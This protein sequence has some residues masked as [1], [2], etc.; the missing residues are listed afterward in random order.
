ML[1]ILSAT[2]FCSI[3]DSGRAGFQRFGLPAAGPMDPFA[4]AAANLLAGNAPQDG[5]AALEIGLGGLALRGHA[6]C[7]VA[8]A[9]PGLALRCD[10]L[11]LPAWTAVYLPAGALVEVER[12]GP[13]VWGYLAVCGGLLTPPVMGSRAFYRPAGL[14]QAVQPGDRLPIAPQPAG[15]RQRAGAG[16]P[17]EARLPYSLDLNLCALPGPQQDRFTAQ[18]L[19]TFYAAPFS[20]S[21]A[22]DRTGYRLEGPRLAHTAAGADIL[23]AGV[24]PGCVQVPAAGRPLVLM[25]DAPTSGGYALIA[26]LPA[27]ERALL[28]QVPPGAGQIRFRPVELDEAQARTRAQWQKLRAGIQPAED[29]WIEQV[30]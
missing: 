29:G 14:G 11:A 30:R 16:L 23:S 9:G 18:A 2:P 22:C 19:E 1:E 10:G 8:L 27:P 13:G 25:A 5:A 20:L 3:Q 15:F 6:D 12:S 21:E 7:L 4:F 28:A 17:T 26:S 24:T